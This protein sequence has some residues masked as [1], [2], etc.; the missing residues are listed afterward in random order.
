MPNYILLPLEQLDFVSI[1]PV[2]ELPNGERLFVTID[3]VPIVL[4]NIAGGLFAI[5]D[6]CT[7][8]GNPL[9][10]APL[11]GHVVICPRHGARF[12]VRDGKALAM[13]A[14]EDITAYPVRVVDG[15]I[16]LGWPR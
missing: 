10:E 15:Q 4:F 7:H 6:T 12:D 13:P 2:N 1:A 16:E 3:N 8:D 5:E 11:E 14:V 9:D